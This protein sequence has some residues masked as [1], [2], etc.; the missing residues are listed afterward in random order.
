[1]KEL[2]LRKKR[3]KGTWKR[4]VSLVVALAVLFSLLPSNLV[5]F[6]LPFDPGKYAQAADFT[7]QDGR[8]TEIGEG[9]TYKMTSGSATFNLFGTTASKHSWTI[10]D[11][12]VIQDNGSNATS[13]TVKALKQ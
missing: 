7:I 3:K 6:Q 2:L 4:R 10:G 12:T 8:G 5:L 11:T 9:D 1:M 13:I